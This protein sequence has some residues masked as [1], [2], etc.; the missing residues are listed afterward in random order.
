MLHIAVY[1]VQG[2]KQVANIAQG[3]G[4]CYFCQ[5]TPNK[6]CYK[7]SSSVLSVLL[8]LVVILVG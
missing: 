1:T 2:E 8:H 3:K 5:G 7:Q 4:E 6:C